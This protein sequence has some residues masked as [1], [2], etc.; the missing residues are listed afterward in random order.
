MTRNGEPLVVIDPAPSK[1]K[2]VPFGVARE[3]GEI[4]GDLIEPAESSTVWE[5]L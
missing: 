4:K 5:S 1:R 3:T 2:R